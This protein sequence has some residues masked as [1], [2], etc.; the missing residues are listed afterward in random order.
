MPHNPNWRAAFEEEAARLRLVA[1]IE[2]HHIGST[3]VPAIL[4]KP[5]I[6]ILGEVADLAMLDKTAGQ[7]ESLGYEVMGAFGIE[8]RR[9]FRKCDAQ[10]VRTHH[11]HV[12]TV[13]SEHITRHLVF[14][15]YLRAHPED[16]RAYSHLKARLTANR[17]DWGAYQ[18][19]KADFVQNVEAKALAWASGREFG[20]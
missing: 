18:D 5:I 8:G 7:F 9:Y 2:L 3:A 16:A 19:G 6:D 17:A 1:P 4:A 20:V 15:D 14:R 12:F 11:L 13:G 10:G